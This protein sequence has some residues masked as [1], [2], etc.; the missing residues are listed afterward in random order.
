MLYGLVSVHC[1]P[2]GNGRHSRMIADIIIEKK[3]QLPVFTWGG[4]SLSVDMD[5]RAQDLKEII[6]DSIT[7]L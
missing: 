5:I 6:N 1:F 2:N 4:A 3:Y 7:A